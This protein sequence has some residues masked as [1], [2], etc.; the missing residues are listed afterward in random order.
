MGYKLLKYVFA[1]ILFILVTSLF[2]FLIMLSLLQDW[3]MGTLEFKQVTLYIEPLYQLPI[4]NYRENET[5]RN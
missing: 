5:G 3:R 4:L 1:Y 2:S